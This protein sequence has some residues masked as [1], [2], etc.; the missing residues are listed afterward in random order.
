MWLYYIALSCWLSSSFVY[1]W[2][3]ID[4]WPRTLIDNTYFEDS[5]HV[6]YIIALS[7]KSWKLM[8]HTEYN[9]W[10]TIVWISPI[11][12]GSIHLSNP[13]LKINNYQRIDHQI[14]FRPDQLSL[15]CVSAKGNVDLLWA[16]VP[17]SCLTSCNIYIYT[18][19]WL[20]H[21]SI[22]KRT[23]C[24]CV[25]FAFASVTS[26]IIVFIVPRSSS[27]HWPFTAIKHYHPSL[28][29]TIRQLS[30]SLAMIRMA[31]FHEPRCCSA[32]KI[33]KAYPLSKTKV[34][35]WLLARDRFNY[36]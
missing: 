14:C 24:V 17:I 22:Y 16:C 31:C 35:Q 6:W 33:D 4:D 21:V 5:I 25:G 8:A 36:D 12:V 32:R 27:H 10:T 26:A 1:D 30:P 9:Q 15:W 20:V 28:S 7:E 11:L 2:S 34:H 18:F 29:T 13:T 19:G 23:V 3:S